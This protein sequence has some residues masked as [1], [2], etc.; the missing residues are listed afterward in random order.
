MQMSSEVQSQISKKS[1]VV[2]GGNLAVTGTSGGGAATILLRHQL[3]SVSS[4]ELMASAGLRALIG[5]QTSR[6]LSPHSTA[7]TGLTFS[8]RDGS[9]NLSNVWTRQLSETANGNIQLVLGTEN[10]IGVGWQKKDE[11]NS[12][13]GEIK[14]GVGSFGATAHYTRHFSSK[15]HGRLAGRIGSTA[16][17]FEVGGGRKISDFSTVRFLYTI[18]IQGVLWRIELH[19]GGQKLIVPVL[20]SSQLSPLLAT[21]ALTVPA[22]I[23]F[24]LKK[25]VFKPYYLKREKL[26]A[27]EKRQRTSSQVQ[28][29]RAAAE[30]SQ[31]LLKNVANRKKNKQLETRGLVITSSVYGNL[32]AYKKRNGNTVEETDD[33]VQQVLDVTIPL[34][35]LI[36]DAGYLKLHKGIKKSGI[37]GFCDPCPEDPKQ[38]FVEYTYK[39]DKH[40]VTVDDYDELIIPQE[41]HRL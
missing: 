22:S 4:L 41:L 19:R 5:L 11:K 25:F 36:N 28:E 2:I 13:A 30:K 17:E 18:G 12:A 35:F 31:L 33:L 10:S 7:T 21:G 38:L 8:L 40:E 16:L 1:T 34:N 15:S 39:G 27:Q 9:I 32:K 23:Y 37:M 26:K 3:S 6:H 29:A 14:F 24:L 20:L